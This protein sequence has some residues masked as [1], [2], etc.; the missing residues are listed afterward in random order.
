[1]LVEGRSGGNAVWKLGT[2]V[3]EICMDEGI[4]V[5]H[6]ITKTHLWTL[7]PMAIKLIIIKIFKNKIKLV[8]LK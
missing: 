2:L 3:G 8:Y 6:F 7:Y 5:R 4:V 1:M